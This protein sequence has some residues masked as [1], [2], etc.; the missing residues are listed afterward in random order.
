MSATSDLRAAPASL[1][2]ALDEIA[3]GADERDAR[4]TYGSVKK[5][6]RRGWLGYVE[7]G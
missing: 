5:Q 7:L 2:A 6:Y 4:P 3:G 1:A